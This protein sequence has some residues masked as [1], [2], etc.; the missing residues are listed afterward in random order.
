MWRSASSSGLIPLRRFAEQ[1]PQADDD[2]KAAE[3]SV[4]QFHIQG[5][6]GPGGPARSRPVRSEWPGA[7]CPGRYIHFDVGGQGR[8]RGGEKVEQIDPWARVW[9]MPAKAVI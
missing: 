2:E 7:G 8:G 6:S 9:G 5:G 1:L 4:E 3:A